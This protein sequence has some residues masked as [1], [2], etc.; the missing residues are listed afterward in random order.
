MEATFNDQI[1]AE[2][3]KWARRKSRSLFGSGRKVSLLLRAAQ[4]LE[5]DSK[6]SQCLR[7]VLQKANEDTLRGKGTLDILAAQTGLAE[8]DL[9]AVARGEIEMPPSMIYCLWSYLD[10]DG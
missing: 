9:W 8:K 7:Y 1:A 4:S 2:L 5:W 6:T 10:N 3:S